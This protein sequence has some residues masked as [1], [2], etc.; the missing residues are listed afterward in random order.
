MPE[1]VPMAKEAR[2]TQKA[3]SRSARPEVGRYKR[4]GD[5]LGQKQKGKKK[6]QEERT[7]RV[8]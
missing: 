6:L 2:E 5:A 3:P 8:R 4:E 7:G 1:K